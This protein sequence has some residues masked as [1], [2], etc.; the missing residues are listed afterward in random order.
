MRLSWNEFRARASAVVKDWKDAAL[1]RRFQPVM[2][3]GPG[4]R[5]Q[6]RSCGG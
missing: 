4:L 2:V 5:R 6:S 3:Q 1:A